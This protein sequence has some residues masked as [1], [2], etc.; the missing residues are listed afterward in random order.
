M[1]DNTLLVRGVTFDPDGSVVV[2]YCAPDQDL[3]ANGVVVNHILMVPVGD[4][5]DDEIETVLTAIQALLVDVL[6]DLPVMKPMPDPSDDEA[7]EDD[8]EDA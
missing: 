6:E 2:E 1:L 8:D 5:Y 7:D 3:K 4:Q